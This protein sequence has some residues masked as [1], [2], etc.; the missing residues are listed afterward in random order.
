M[1]RKLITS[2]VFLMIVSLGTLLAQPWNV[3]QSVA[4]DASN[5]YITKWKD[6]TNHYIQ[7]SLLYDDGSYVG[8]NYASP[9]YM[10]DIKGRSRIISPDVSNSAGIWYT[11]SNSTTNKAFIGMGTDDFVG[12]YSP[13]ISPSSLRWGFHMDVTTGNVGIGLGATTAGSK[14]EVKG[15]LRLSG[16]TSGYVGFAPAAAAGSTTYTLP[17]ADGSSGQVL[18][19]NGSATLSWATPVTTATAWQITGNAGLTDATNF[20]GTTAAAGD[21]PLN[22]RVNN[23]K[24]GRISDAGE[25]F[26]GYQAGNSNTATS[27]TGIGFKALFSN[28]TGVYN[29]ATGDSALYSNTTGTCNTANGYKALYSNTTEEANTAVGY[30]ALYT[31][32]SGKDNAALGYKALYSN[33]TAP[34]N[35]AVGTNALY[36][37]TTGTPNTA[38]GYGA[39]YANTT[40]YYNTAIG[41]G[42]GNSNANDTSCTFLGS[43]ADASGN[44]SNA[45]AIGYGASVTATN[46]IK[47]GNTS[48]TQIGGCQNWTNTSDGRFK[49]NVIENVKGL[50]F[51][52]KLRPVTY[53]LNTQQLDYFF[54]QNM[55]ADDQ[56]MHQEGMDFAPS[57]AIVHSG[58]IAQE[59]D[60]VANSC[61][62]TSSIVHTPAN[63]TD[64][65]ALSYAEFVVP[66]VKAVQELSKTV[67]SLKLIMQIYYPQGTLN[68]TLQNTS[69]EQL[70]SLRIHDIELANNAVLYQNAP[71]PFSDG[72]TIKYFVPENANVQI[73]FMDEFGNHIKEF[74]I[75][76]KGMGQLN[77][78]ASNLAAG[79]YS[80]SLIV[81]GRVVDTKKMIKQ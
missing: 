21:K 53:Q 46:Y 73:V 30:Q 29:T 20:L 75:E 5:N 57:T 6:A 9:A 78:S 3:Q 37:N 26:L 27:N 17:T 14:L 40:G 50:E 15:T 64:P 24:A 62:F 38:T 63:S 1:K 25:T 69:D 33:T 11:G 81:N 48:V 19:T 18:Q 47:V 13:A 12:F 44:Y 22:F 71:N 51:I 61:G 39:L 70:N 74:S 72:T 80:Y 35:T 23:Q 59:V 31:N 76:E 77:V 2:I 45:T 16:S 58:F 56:A 42:A 41:Y 36:S 79:M 7:K 28:T 49:F 66:L 67:D 8:V 10:M 65:Y 32:T 34:A 43:D 55:S 68:K 60:S 52:K 54:I 4:G